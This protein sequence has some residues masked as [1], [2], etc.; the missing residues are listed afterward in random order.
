MNIHCCY[1][2]VYVSLYMFDVAD[3]ADITCL[4][5]KCLFLI[6]VGGDI[7][8][9]ESFGGR[10]PLVRATAAPATEI[11]TRLDEP[12]HLPRESAAVPRGGAGV[13]QGA[14]LV[15]GGEAYL[16]LPARRPLV[17]GALRPRADV[18]QG[19]RPV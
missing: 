5:L 13:Y 18:G 15:A 3:I 8:E 12:R 19:G 9:F 6:A 14:A 4:F 7:G 17:H 1:S 11:S 2:H 10:D 16:G